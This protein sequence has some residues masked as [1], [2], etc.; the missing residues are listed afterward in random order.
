[1]IHLFRLLGDYLHA[2]SILVILVI[3]GSKGNGFGIS[4]KSH[5]LYLAVF[6]LRYLDLFQAFYSTY[7]FMMKLYFIATTTGV[8]YFLT[9]V[10]PAK[11]TYSPVQDSVNHWTLLFG[12]ATAGLV[13]HLVGSGVVDI[14]GSSGQ[15][16]EVHL[17]HYRYA[18]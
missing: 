14:K 10:E 2:A 1:M 8:I 13:I 9:R 12:A 17:Q 11:S 18:I 3:V 4:L 7:N 15:E 16:F 5:Y 6:C